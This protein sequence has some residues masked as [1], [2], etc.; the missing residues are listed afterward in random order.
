MLTPIPIPVPGLLIRLSSYL[1]SSVLRRFYGKQELSDLLKIKVCSEPAGFTII[2]SGLP[3]ASAWIE[4]HNQSPFHVTLHE[5]EADFFLPDRVAKFV[6]ICNKDIKAKAMERLF[7]EIDLTGK[8]VDYVRRHKRCQTASLKIN[9]LLSC[10]LS[11][12]EITGREIS[13]ENIQFVD[14]SDS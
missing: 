7:V 2:C 8:Q 12:F 13:L 1:C 6:K 5:F 9:S 11:S 14:C 4:I 3:R 10:R